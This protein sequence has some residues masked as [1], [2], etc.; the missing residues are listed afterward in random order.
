MKNLILGAIAAFV[1]VSVSFG[2][3]TQPASAG[4]DAK[5]NAMVQK[6]GKNCK[7]KAVE[8][9]DVAQSDVSVEVG[10]TLQ[11]SIDAGDVTLKNI[12]KDGLS[13]NWIVA[14]DGKKTD[15]YCNTDGK[16]KVTEFK[17]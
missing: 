6:A 8:Q 11:Q 12:Q 13:F 3:V 15:G 1:L 2:I 7:S 9:F 4:D 14:R 10:A 17:Q 5:I 16:G